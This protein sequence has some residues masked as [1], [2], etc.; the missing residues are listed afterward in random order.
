MKTIKIAAILLLA[1]IFVSCNPVEKNIP[2]QITLQTLTVTQISSTSIPRQTTTPTVNLPTKTPKI[3]FQTTLTEQAFELHATKIA[4]FHPS[5]KDIGSNSIS[6]NG[7]WLAVSCGYVENQALEI[8]SKEGKQWVLKFKDYLP[9]TELAEGSTPMGSLY[10]I[11]WTNDENYLYFSSYIAVDGGGPCFYGFGP[12][13]VYRI[14]LTTGSVT[15]TLQAR[16]AFDGYL[17]AFSPDGSKIA[18]STTHLVVRDLKTG[19]DFVIKSGDNIIGNL[20]WSPDGSELAFAS[21]E[22]ASED[23][24][25][26]TSS[27]EIFS[28]NS[29]TTKTIMNVEKNFLSIESWSGRPILKIVNE[30]SH[31]NKTTYSFYDWFLGEFIQATSSP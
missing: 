3:D 30:D 20:T 5:C 29:H 6:P 19:N 15:T 25:V 31:S 13:G 2:T 16:P 7:D 24:T 11:L 14:N 22:I 26:K 12:S 1:L 17:I 23:F 9:E 4:N 21:C 27:I 18:Y 10:P 28:L 8:V